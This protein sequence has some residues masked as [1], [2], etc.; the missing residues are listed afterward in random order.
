MIT[1]KNKDKLIEDIKDIFCDVWGYDKFE[2]YE[3]ELSKGWIKSLFTEQLKKWDDQNLSKFYKNLLDMN[4]QFEQTMD[5]LV[6]MEVPIYEEKRIE[7]LMSNL[8]EEYI[9]G[10]GS[11][12]KRSGLDVR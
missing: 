8:Y 5:G 10:V 6:E 1:V 7:I 12:F 2:D 3:G 4:F 9:R 11:L